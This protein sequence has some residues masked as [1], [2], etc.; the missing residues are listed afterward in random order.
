MAITDVPNTY[1]LDFGQDVT[2]SGTT[3]KGILDMPDKDEDQLENGAFLYQTQQQL[4]DKYKS[5]EDFIIN[6]EKENGNWD[7]DFQTGQ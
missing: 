1:L 2:F 4:V 3:V 7:R 6:T 5:I